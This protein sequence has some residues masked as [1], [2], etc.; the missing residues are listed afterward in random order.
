LDPGDPDSVAV[1]TGHHGR[2][3]SFT[4]R[5]LANAAWALAELRVLEEEEFQE[6]LAKIWRKPMGI[7]RVLPQF[8]FFSVTFG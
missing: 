8:P 3:P 2:C 6:S 1:P 4:P 7:H 5:H